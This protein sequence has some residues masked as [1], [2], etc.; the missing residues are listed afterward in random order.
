MASSAGLASLFSSYA[1]ATN[2]MGWANLA[3]KLS[4]R[5]SEVRL[6]RA[7][8][9]EANGDQTAAVSDYEKVVADRPDDYVLWLA[10]A[11]AYEMGGDPTRSIAAAREAVKLAPSYAEPRWQLGNILVRA[12]NGAE[13]FK[14]LS[15]TAD[16]DQT[17]LPGIIDLAWHLLN[18]NPKAVEQAISPHNSEGYRALASFFQ[19]QNQIDEAI[20]MFRSA[21]ADADSDVRGYVAEL[22]SKGKYSQ[23]Y[24]LWSLNHKGASAIT[25][26]SFE[27]ESDLTEPG[28]EWRIADPPATNCRFTLDSASAKEGKLSLRVEFSGDSDPI[29]PIISQLVLV[30]PLTRYELRFAEHSQN[31]LSAGLPIII[32]SDAGS[33]STLGKSEQLS[34]NA[35]DWREQVINFSTSRTTAAIQIRVQREGCAAPCPIFGQLWLDAFSLRKL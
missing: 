14:E 20:A 25:D 13:G 26:G 19:R 10:L 33:K 12:G 2:R 32:I 30:Q 11:R 4:G 8:L 21:G 23:A 18:N 34:P 5:D 24:T 17:L 9:S 7:A 31:L 29:R 22:I 16:S 6:A 1:V 27:T 28:F 35:P 15:T 3:V